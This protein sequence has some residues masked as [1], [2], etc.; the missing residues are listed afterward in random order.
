MAFVTA[1]LDE[2]GTDDK[3]TNTVVCA[4]VAKNSSWLKLDSQWRAILRSRGISAFHASEFHNSRGE[5]KGW[6]EQ[7]KE[8]LS[9]RLMTVIKKEISFFVAHSVVLSEFNKVAREFPILHLSPYEMLLPNCI[10]ALGIWMQ[11]HPRTQG[12]SIKIEAGQKHGHGGIELLGNS[13]ELGFLWEKERISEIS[14]VSKKDITPFQVSDL[15]A[16]ELYQLGHQYSESRSLDVDMRVLLR[17]IL[18]SK[19]VEGSIL[20]EQYIRGW[21]AMTIKIGAGKKRA[22]NW[23]RKST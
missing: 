2:S 5:F 3:S 10:V 12:L 21:F 13:D 11:K 6:T 17:E 14:Y 20:E 7:R 23:F 8:D 22:K 15:V 16:Y 9:K 19:N 4:S 18:K 1:Y